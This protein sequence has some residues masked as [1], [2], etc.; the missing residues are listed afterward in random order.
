MK[1]ALQART[2]RHIAG[3][4]QPSL[5]L[6]GNWLTGLREIVVVS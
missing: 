6:M 2:G 1:Q 3:R 5:V 4:Q